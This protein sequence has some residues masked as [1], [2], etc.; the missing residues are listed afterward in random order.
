MGRLKKKLREPQT[1]TFVCCFL[2]GII[3]VSFVFVGIGGGFLKPVGYK[4]DCNVTTAA[5]LTCVAAWDK[6][7]ASSRLYTNKCYCQRDYVTYVSGAPKSPTL[8]TGEL[9]A[10]KT[11]SIY[12]RTEDC[13][14]LF[15]AD[16]KSVDCFWYPLGDEIDNSTAYN[17]GDK[18]DFQSSNGVFAVGM[19]LCFIA[20]VVN[21][22]ILL[23]S[24][25]PK[26]F[27]CF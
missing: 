11:R 6:N 16:E 21:I 10:W 9:L 24:V 13:E 4:L 27:S 18:T 15:P 17:Y 2:V 26:V 20:I 19:L 12:N 5:R 22:Y 8:I 23:V 1:A 25:A 7:S 14:K 3:G